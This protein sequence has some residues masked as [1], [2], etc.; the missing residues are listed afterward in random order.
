[1]SAGAAV[2][3]RVPDS[4]E[5]PHAGQGSVMLDIGGDI[6]ALVVTTPASMVGVEVEIGPEGAAFGHHPDHDHHHDHGH[7][8]DH[9]HL[10]HVAVVRRPVQ[11]GE[12]PALVFGE[13]SAGRYALAEKS[14]SDVRLVVD[15]RGGEVTSVEWPPEPTEG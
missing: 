10:A 1:M 12:V 6:G 8:H 4:P 3:T 13:L 14:T 2:E 5:N 15:V 9:G 7:S 11:G